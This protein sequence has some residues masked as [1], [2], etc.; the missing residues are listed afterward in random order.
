MLFLTFI[1]F[2]FLFSKDWFHESCLNLR[3]RPSSREPTPAKDSHEETQLTD[4]T[5]Q[6]QEDDD[7]TSEASCSGLPPP[8]ISAYDYESFVCGSCV[9]GIATLKRWAGTRGVMMVVR[10]DA[11]AP[12]KVLGDARE[13]EEGDNEDIDTTAAGTKRARPPSSGN[14]PEAKRPRPSEGLST[15]CLAPPPN[16][17]AQNIF[18]LRNSVDNSASLGMG[19]VFLTEGWRERWC[20]C[21]SVG[22]TLCICR[23]VP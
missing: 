16:P 9:S 3:E 21:L 13:G 19:D 4:T 7:N 18:A 2:S 14:I 23:P 5:A 10:D 12:W 20:R 1:I 6:P 15:S 22:S 11:S 17:V 8:L